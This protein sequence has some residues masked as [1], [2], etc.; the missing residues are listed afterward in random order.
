MPEQGHVT[1]QLARTIKIPELLYQRCR[2]DQECT[3]RTRITIVSME[4]TISTT[5]IFIASGS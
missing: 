2:S 4:K 1:G 5:V 3:Y